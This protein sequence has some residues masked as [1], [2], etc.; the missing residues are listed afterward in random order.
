MKLPACKAEQAGF[1]ESAYLLEQNNAVPVESHAS[2]FQLNVRGE[3]GF[4]D[5]TGDGGG[6]DGRRMPVAD[7]I[8]YNKYRAHPALLAADHRRQIG[9]I[10]LS[11]FDHVFH[12]P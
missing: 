2:G 10:D 4:A 11:S 3:S 6:D 9:V 7:V 1:I 12:T 8:L 5:L